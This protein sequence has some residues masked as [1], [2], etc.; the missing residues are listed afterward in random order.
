MSG[1]ATPSGKSHVALIISL[2]VN[3]LLVGLIVMSF[4]RMHFMGPPPFGPDMMDGHGRGHG[5]MLWQTQQSLTPQA[6]L[7]AAPAKSEKI[8]SIVDA[9]HP[10]VR[11]LAESSI[12]ARRDAL[13]VFSAQVFDKN[14]FDQSLTRVQAADAALEKEILSV[15]SE[16]AGTLSPDERRAVASEREHHGGGMWG[17]HFR[18]GF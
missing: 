3:L 8:R 18:H 2:C 10:R 6:F 1:T 17:H 14:V 16:S 5:M 9:H 11:E 4:V 13:K 12:A 7:H 15:V